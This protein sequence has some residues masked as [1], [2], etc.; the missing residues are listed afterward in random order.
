MTPE[1]YLRQY[2]CTPSCNEPLASCSLLTN[3]NSAISSAATCSNSTTSPSIS[4]LSCCRPSMVNALQLLCGNTLSSLTD[5]SAFYFLTDTLS[6]GSALSVPTTNTDNLSNTPTAVLRRFAPCNCDLL[7]VS[8]TAYYALPGSTDVAL[9]TVDQLSLC[10]VKVVAFQVLNN[11]C[12]TENENCGYDCAVR[13]LR[14]AIQAEGGATNGCATCQSHCD[15]ENC[16]CAS[17]LI[18]ELSTRN[19]SRQATITVGPLVLQN[20]TVLGSIGSVLV[21]TDEALNRVYLV[22]S[23]AIE[24]IG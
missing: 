12:P 6:I 18:S 17:G 23:N 7:E 5:F 20:V 19:L 15:C 24:A 2:H 8:G 10:A 11:D 1:A 13:A 9:D 4:T 22:C 14:R 16:S 21:L 3:A